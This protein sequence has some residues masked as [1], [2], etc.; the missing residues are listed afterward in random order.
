MKVNVAP[1]IDRTTTVTVTAEGN[2]SGIGL[3]EA[4]CRPDDVFSRK[5]GIL[6]AT[7]RA[8]QDLGRKVEDAGHAQVVSKAEVSRVMDAIGNAWTRRYVRRM[9]GK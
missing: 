8:F 5:T 6:I 9:A 2:F 1:V 4:I 3:G 7:G